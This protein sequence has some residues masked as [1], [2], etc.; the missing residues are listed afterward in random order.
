MIAVSYLP[1]F[2]EKSD[3]QEPKGDEQASRDQCGENDDPPIDRQSI[4]VGG[5]QR[6]FPAQDAGE[7]DWQES[8]NC[9]IE[10]AE[11]RPDQQNVEVSRR[12]HVV[13]NAETK[14]EIVTD[15]SQLGK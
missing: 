4:Q 15:Q 6:P 11:R 2:T 14:V 1:S 10:D 8:R 13:A 3:G 5:R 12:Q 9:F 7:A